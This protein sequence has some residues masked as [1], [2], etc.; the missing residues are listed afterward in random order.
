MT[1]IPIY[2]NPIVI[3]EDEDVLSN[4]ILL[5]FAA[6]TVGVVVAA[7]LIVKKILKSRQTKAVPQDNDQQH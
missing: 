5:V 7:V 3:P 6:I 4:A 2:L 1:R